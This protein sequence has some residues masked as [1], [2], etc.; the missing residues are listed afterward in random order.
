MSIT[1]IIR[2]SVL[3]TSLTMAV[4]SQAYAL[5]P[6]EYCP[7]GYA[8]LEDIINGVPT[9]VGLVPVAA[10]TVAAHGGAA[11]AA[12]SLI[13]GTLTTVAGCALPVC[14]GAA[15]VGVP[16]ATGIGIVGFATNPGASAPCS[17]TTQLLGIQNP[18]NGDICLL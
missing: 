13:G 7:A 2:R 14:V 12:C 17:P 16:A 18:S 10:G 6:A 8:V 4:A 11:N 1:T 3:L 15:I 9:A 5:N